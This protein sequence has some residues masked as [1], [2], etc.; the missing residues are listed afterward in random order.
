VRL[1]GKVAVVTGGAQ[2]IGR[3]Y[4][5]GFA[6]E[7]AAV[8]V[9]DLRREQAEESAAAPRAAGARAAAYPGDVADQLGR[10]RRSHARLGGRWLGRRISRL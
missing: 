8:A 10:R 6:R 5:Q 4:C 2:G 9:V 7:G 1:A 3:A